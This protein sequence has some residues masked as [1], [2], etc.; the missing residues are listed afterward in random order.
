M[1]NE[2]IERIQITGLYDTTKKEDAVKP[3]AGALPI[4]VAIAR[5]LWL[6]PTIVIGTSSGE[7]VAEGNMPFGCGGTCGYSWRVPTDL[8]IK[9]EK[10]TFTAVV[11]YDTL[12]LYGKAEFTHPIVMEALP[13][14]KK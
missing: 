11:T 13:A 5:P 7:N 12:D 14:E 8:K 2:P 6:D 10:E 9:G 3:P 4:A 1:L